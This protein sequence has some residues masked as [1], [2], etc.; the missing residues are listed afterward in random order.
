MR[1]QD[2]AWPAHEPIGCLTYQSVASSPPTEAELDDLVAKARKRNNSVGVTGMLLYE[3]GKFLQTLEGPPDGLGAIWSSIQ[4]DP[5]HA[6]IEVLTQHLVPGRLFSSWDLLLYRKREQAPMGLWDRLRSERRVSSHVG[7]ASKLALAA[8]DQGLR[9]LL[10]RLTAKGWNGDELARDLLEPTARA[11]G[12][13]WLAD[14]CSEFDLTMALGILQRAAHVVR[15]DH[16][17]A[18]LAADARKILLATAPGEPHMLGTS[19]LADQFF[20]AGWDVEVAYPASNDSLANQLAHQCPNALD[21]ALSDALPRPSRITQ[22]RE[23]VKHSRSAMPDQSLVVSVG[24][25]LFAENEAT[26]EHVGADYARPT[27]AG[28][29]PQI[30]ELIKHARTVASPD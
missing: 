8:N 22:L 30:G 15:Y 9:D 17:S 2:D 11:L 3:D 10:T 25:R 5:R 24:G 18:E 21:I 26:A 6:N 4:R 13:V 28:T 1:F 12:D 19:L 27:T 14:E 20:D 23:T 16:D 7:T 29:Q